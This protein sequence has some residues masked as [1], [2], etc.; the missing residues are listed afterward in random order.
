A[1]NTFQKVTVMKKHSSI[2][3]SIF[4]SAI[5]KHLL[6]TTALTVAGVVAASSAQAVGL[7]ETPTGGTVVAGGSSIS[8]SGANMTV[9]QTT[10]RAVINWQTYSIVQNAAATYNQPN[11]SA[12]SVNRV[13]GG[14]DPSQ[15]LGTLKSN[16][17]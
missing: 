7:D 1:A 8:Y 13:T 2:F 17:Q 16:G 11:A 10:Q 15:I 12:L 6:A 14:N 9:N 4:G 3:A 5:E